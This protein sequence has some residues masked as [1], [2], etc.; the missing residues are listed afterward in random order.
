M[1][2]ASCL[3]IAVCACMHVCVCVCVC[4]HACVFVCPCA[5]A[6]VVCGCKSLLDAFDLH[7]RMGN[8]KCLATHK[9]ILQATEVSKR[10]FTFVYSHM[11]IVL[12]VV[13]KPV[14]R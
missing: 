5:F 1:N 9:I 4:V 7:V 10:N 11:H 2:T 8:H 6:H 13:L 12:L 3:Q 14:T